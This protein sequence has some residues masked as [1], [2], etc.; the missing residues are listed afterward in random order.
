LGHLVG[1]GFQRLH[2][3]GLFFGRTDVGAIAA[4]HAVFR[5][6]LHAELVL[7]ELLADGLLASKAAGAL[8][9]L[10]VGDQ[11]GTDGGM[12]ADHGALVALDAVVHDPFGH[13]DGHAA[14]FILVV[15][16]GKCRRA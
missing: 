12:R 3:Q 1:L 13:I 15:A 6:D 10:I 7:L 4:A 8:A 11:E 16:T 2:H 14:L 5:I 9:K